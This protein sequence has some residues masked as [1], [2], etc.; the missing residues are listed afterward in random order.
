MKANGTKRVTL[1]NWT[2]FQQD[3][4][5]ALDDGATPLAAFDADGTLWDMDIGENFFQ[6]QARHKLVE[7]PPN[8]WEFYDQWHQR[9]PIPA[10]LWL[11]QINAGQPLSQVRE[12]AAQAVR[13][14]G[15][16]PIFPHMRRLIEFLKSQGVQVLVVT[17]SVKWAV[18]P[19]AALLGI[20]HEDVVGIVTTVDEQGLVGRDAGGPVTWREGKVDGLLKRSGG[21]HPF[22][23][24]GNTMGDFS[25]IEQ[26]TH[27][28]FA[29][30]ASPQSSGIHA[31][32]REL[33]REAM[34]RGWYYLDL[35]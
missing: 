10:Y 9:E 24:A 33:I 30:T 11:A 12:W 29:H 21:Q 19:A 15:E 4:Q 18:E 13:E 7:L 3:I 5:A 32:E 1:E 20:P 25:L 27:I 26:A 8:P 16:I 6:F 28:P 23:A 17:A 34:T 31:T 14:S 22:L 35:V 2:Q